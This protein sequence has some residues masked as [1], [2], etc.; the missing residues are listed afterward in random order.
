MTHRLHRLLCVLLG[1]FAAT[2]LLACSGDSAPEATSTPPATTTPM[3]TPAPVPTPVPPRR[4]E[5]TA[6]PA[7]LAQW[8]ADAFASVA[9]LRGTPPK[10]DV[11]MFLLTRAQARAYY[12]ADRPT[13]SVEPQPRSLD[14]KQE[15][16]QLLGLI[17]PRADLGQQSLDNLIALI[18]GFY[19]PELDAL[20]VLEEIIGGLDGIGARTTIV[21][22][23]VHALQDQHYDIALLDAERADDWDARTALLDVMEGEAIAT[24]IAY[25]GFST[26]SSYRVP[27]CFQIPPPIRPGVPFIVER[28]LDTWYEDGLCFVQAVAPRL[29]DGLAALWDD[30]P[31]T[32]EQVLH[33]EKYLAGEGAMPVTLRSLDS[34]LGEGWSQLA[35]STLGEFT[36]QNILLA[37]LAEERPLVQGAAAGWGGDRWALYTREDARLVH[38][39]TLWDSDAEAREFWDA[40]LK[41]IYNRGEGLPPIEDTRL[42]I[43]L[44]GRTW[45]A[46]LQGNR[47]AFL[48]SNDPTALEAAAQALGLP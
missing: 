30:L 14:A 41:S 27:V 47:V 48:V 40:F 10:H 21:H 11:D 22:E 26:R 24:E 32:T 17:G 3:P 45:R 7:A 2:A 1:V 25:F 37:G 39:V 4:P 29:P 43:G 19:S 9:E 44:D 12:G 35:S 6:F 38:A 46:H 16:Y 31:T 28:E 20:Y 15:L 23:L 36:L 42:S 13:P 34:V 5:A 8:A 18:T 33:P